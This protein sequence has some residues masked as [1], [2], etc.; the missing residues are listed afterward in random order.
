MDQPLPIIAVSACLLGEAVR[1]DGKHK[2]SGAVAVL[3]KQAQLVAI[4]PEVA[5]GLGIPRPPIE[6]RILQREI[7]VVQVDNHQQ[8]HTEALA[9]YA[10][11][12]GLWCLEN[13]VAGYILMPKSPSCAL[14]SSR[15]YQQNKLLTEQAE[16]HFI[17]MLKEHVPNMPMIEEPDLAGHEVQFL[18][19]VKQYQNALH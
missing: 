7:N 4:C 17:R 3:A 1:Y 5:I 9:D 6:Q 10:Q 8:N 15:I 19:R 11:R 12:I 14:Q 16:G 18:R 13:S 2:A